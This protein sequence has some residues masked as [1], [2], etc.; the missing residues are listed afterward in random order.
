MQQAAVHHMS[1]STRT[2][3]LLEGLRSMPVMMGGGDWSLKRLRLPLCG[4]RHLPLARPPVQHSASPSAR[5][6]ECQRGEQQRQLLLLQGS[7][8]EA[9]ASA[10]CTDPQ[11]TWTPIKRH[12]SLKFG[13]YHGGIYGPLKELECAYKV[14]LWK[15]LSPPYPNHIIS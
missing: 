15:A 3:K 13:I 9:V 5:P 11:L 14:L 7:A 2:V 10:F 4:W 8:S 12:T 6:P 1:L